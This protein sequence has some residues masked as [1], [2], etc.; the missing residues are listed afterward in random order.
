[1]STRHYYGNL[2]MYAF[3]RLLSEYV[4]CMY[5]WKPEVK[6]RKETYMRILFSRLIQ[7]EENW[8]NLNV[9]KTDIH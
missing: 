2:S 3:Q 7:T 5:P 4:S 6:D 1:M 8:K 9:H